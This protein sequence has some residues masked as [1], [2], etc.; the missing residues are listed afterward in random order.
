MHVGSIN[1]LDKHQISTKLVLFTPEVTCSASDIPNLRLYSF[2]YWLIHR[3]WNAWLE[4]SQLPKSNK[5]QWM[6]QSK[7]NESKVTTMKYTIDKVISFKFQTLCCREKRF[8]SLKFKFE[9]DITLADSW[10]KLQKSMLKI[11]S[12]YKTWHVNNVGVQVFF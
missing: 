3:E 8:Q 1:P 11:Y 4:S 6:L 10:C 12:M 5:C 9:D 7:Y 2:C